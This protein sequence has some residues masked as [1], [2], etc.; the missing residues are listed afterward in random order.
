LDILADTVH[1]FPTFGE[2]YELPLQ[3]LAG[4]VT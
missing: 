1:A 4:M 2:A 3:E